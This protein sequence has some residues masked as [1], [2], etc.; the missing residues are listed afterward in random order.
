M[1][2]E[3][4]DDEVEDSFLQQIYQKMVCQ[5]VRFFVHNNPTTHSFIFRLNDVGA[6][7]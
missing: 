4:F 2:E 5:D 3:K 1:H 6:K 7:I